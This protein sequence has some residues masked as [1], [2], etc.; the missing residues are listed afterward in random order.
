MA[1]LSDNFDDN[2]IDTAIWDT[3][4]AGTGTVLEQNGQIECA[5]TA[6][7]GFFGLETDIPY[8][9]SEPASVECVP[10][11]TENYFDLA[12]CLTHVTNTNYYNEANWI[13][14][15]PGPVGSLTYF[16][17][18]VAGTVTTIGTIAGNTD[19]VIHKID[20]PASGNDVRFLING[21]EKASIAVYPLSSRTCY[22]FVGGFLS[23]GTL[24]ASNDE[25]DFDNFFAAFPPFALMFRRK[26]MAHMLVR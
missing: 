3:I 11:K 22:F 13:R 14:L 4:I 15:L 26:P 25:I 9:M 18:K 21:V 8:T 6:S 23:A 7:S 2:N 17:Q 24:G 16:Q 10:V 19:G 12:V 5:C 1:T 20:F